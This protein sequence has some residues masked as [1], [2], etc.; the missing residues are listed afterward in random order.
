MRHRFNS[1]TAPAPSPVI[2]AKAGIHWRQQRSKGL[3]RCCTRGSDVNRW[4]LP[5]G[6][7]EWIPAFAGMTEK[8]AYDVANHYGSHPDTSP[9]DRV[10]PNLKDRTNAE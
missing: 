1:S 6:H 3:G 8:G 5:H 4:S 2:P 7:V 10:T 9:S